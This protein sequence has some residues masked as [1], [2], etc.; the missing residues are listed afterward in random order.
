MTVLLLRLCFIST[1]SNTL[2]DE[3][4]LNQRTRAVVFARRSVGPW[5]FH[6]RRGHTAPA[7]P[8]RR[9]K[10]TSPS[11]PILNRC[12]ELVRRVAAAVAADS[13]ENSSVR[14]CSFDD[15]YHQQL[16]L[17]TPSSAMELHQQP[18]QLPRP[19]PPPRSRVGSAGGED[20]S[21]DAVLRFSTMMPPPPPASVA[22]SEASVETRSTRSASTS[23]RTNNRLSLTLPIAPPTAQPS[24]P[25]PTATPS[26]M[27]SYP[28]TPSDTPALLSP[29]EPSDFITAIAAQERR[30]MELR[31]E[32]SRAEHDLGRLKKQW[33]H[34]EAHKKRAEIRRTEPLRPIAAPPHVE[35][36]DDAD[37]AAARRSVD[38]DRR[39]ALLLGQQSGQ[40]TPTQSR[41]RVFRGGHARTLSLLSPVKTTGG[42]AIHEDQQ[43][44]AGDEV[45][46]SP[47]RD[48]ESQIHEA[49]SR[50]SPISPA[51]LS[52]RASWTPRSV[53]QVSG[54][55]QVADDLKTGLWTFVE[56]LRQVT[57]GDEAPRG[58][59]ATPLR[60]ADGV[61]SRP[62]RAPLGDDQDTIR[63]S[64][65]AARPHV[66]RAFEDTPTPPSRFVDP[67]GLVTED[68]PST[69]QQQHKRRPSK[70]AKHFSWAPLTVDSYDDN[71]WSSWDSP[72]VKSTQR[73][74]G[75]TVNE[76][77]SPSAISAK[78]AESTSP[79]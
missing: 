40:N 11:S 47:V 49:F 75:S 21:I 17:A 10:K 53:H 1:C 37:D 3:K 22:G 63:A 34:Q 29:V 66:A 23:S 61:G 56:D 43:S 70:A 4:R 42:F 45:V 36:P 65:P 69:Q 60:G 62:A 32:L 13:S 77:T 18:Q 7:T 5:R 15:E 38:L 64:G 71:D 67:L 44:S 26:T 73:W 20:E 79:L 78:V 72:T 57:V 48:L 2:F 35:A 8:Y 46:K 55:R 30:V 28:P 51:Q 6:H 9:R 41:R 54:L 68:A 50:Y 52:K 27:G 16:L 19:A 58:G 76:E 33:A 25:T 24:R 39:K 59:H 74:S 31:E 12:P 14:S